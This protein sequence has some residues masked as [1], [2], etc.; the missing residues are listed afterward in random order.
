MSKTSKNSKTPIPPNSPTSHLWKSYDSMVKYK[1]DLLAKGKN[2]RRVI[3][4]RNKK[5]GE[6]EV[7]VEKAEAWREE[8]NG[9]AAK[10][11]FALDCIREQMS[12]VLDEKTQWLE[13]KGRLKKEKHALNMRVAHFDMQKEKAIQLALEKAKVNTWA[14]KEKEEITE[15]CHMLIWDL[16]SAEVGVEHIQE[17]IQMV[18][19]AFGVEVDGSFC[20]R[21]V[22]RIVLEGGVAGQ[23]QMAENIN[24]CTGTYLLSHVEQN[25]TK[26]PGLT[27]SGDGT[28]IKNIN[29]ESHHMNFKTSD[30]SVKH[31]FMAEKNRSLFAKMTGGNSDH[32][33]DQKKLFKLLKAYKEKVGYEQQGESTLL[34]MTL[35]EAL[36]LLMEIYWD[37]VD[38]AGGF[39]A[40]LGLTHNEQKLQ[41]DNA[42]LE[43]CK[44]LGKERFNLLSEK[45]RAASKLF[46]WVGCGMHKEMNAFKGAVQSMEEWWKENEREKPPCKLMNR[47]NRAAAE[48]GSSEAATQAVAVS[49]GGAI[50]LTELAG[51]VFHHKDKKKGQQDT[52]KYFAQHVLGMPIVFPDTSNIQYHCHGDASSELLVNY[53]FYFMLLEMVRDKKGAGTFTNLELNMYTGLQDTPTIEEL[54]AI[55]LYSQ[56]VTHP[57]LRTIQ[58][59]EGNKTNAPD[60]GP[61][62][63]RLI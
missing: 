53:D 29:F 20:V 26:K 30:G 24:D 45:E 11:Q 25:L 63:N 50:K 9:E 10:A 57:Y 34:D 23:A 51:A 21:S 16:V 15:S 28:T 52:V 4:W 35:E 36:P 17:V 40:W 22:G 27:V 55:S 3:K 14:V 37:A 19:N 42:Y 54:C 41:N 58:G 46:L 43:F 13:E 2:L 62:H 31:C 49:K 39:T 48:S 8:A 5:I 44:R 33:E 18:A 7:K 32:S 56:S 59:P 6:L 60:L 1:N 47:D 38:K 12:T 61:L